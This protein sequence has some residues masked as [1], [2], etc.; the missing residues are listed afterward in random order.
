MFEGRFPT[1]SNV[2]WTSKLDFVKS[3]NQDV[4]IKV[5]L[6]PEL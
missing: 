3:I 5:I 4:G 2:R 1:C 6:K